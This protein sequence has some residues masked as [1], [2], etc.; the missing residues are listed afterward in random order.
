ML[1]DN[2][3]HVVLAGRLAKPG[4]G[5]ALVYA[6]AKTDA[7]QPNVPMDDLYLPGYAL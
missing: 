3:V 5:V 6:G 7:K 1:G 2:D 4:V